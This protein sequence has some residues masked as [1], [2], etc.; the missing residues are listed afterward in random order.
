MS[1]NGN[2]AVSTWSTAA[3]GETIGKTGAEGGQIF[4]DET[5]DGGAQI[6]LE[7]DCLRAPYAITVLV[8]GWMVHTRFIADEPTAIHEYELMRA[9]LSAI[10][11]VLENPDVLDDPSAVD[12]ALADFAARYP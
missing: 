12:A 6:T 4:R 3:N 9:S 1:N 2:G 7:R 11:T 5:H 10:L 8:Y